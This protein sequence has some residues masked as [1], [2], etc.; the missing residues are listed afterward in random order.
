MRLVAFLLSG[1]TSHHHGMWRHP[2]T[3]NSFL[4]PEYY[5]HIARVLE[6]GYF[7]ALFFAD[8]LALSDFYKGSYETLMTRGGQMGLLDPMPMAA[9]MAR[10][11]KHIGLGVSVSSSFTHAFQTARTFA[12][13]DHLSGGRMAWN[14]VTSSS[15]PTFA[16]FGQAQIPRELRYDMADEVVEACTKLWES[17]EADAL[18][19]DKASGTFADASKIHRVDYEGQYVRTRGP[20]TVPRSPQGWPVLMQAGSSPRGREFAARW[21]EIIF[22]LQH[23]IPDMQD[24]RQDIHARMDKRGRR[25]EECQILVSVDPILGESRGMAEEKAAYL[26]ELIDPELGLALISAHIGTDLSRYPLHQPL[27]EVEIAEGSRGSLDVILQGTRS[28]GLSL[29][30]AAKRFAVSELCPQVIGTAADIADQL[31]AMFDSGGC[32]GFVLTPTTFPGC[33]EQFSRAVVPELQRRGLVRT[34]YDGKTLRENLQA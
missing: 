32:D 27:E 25:P 19:L 11:T 7:D 3:D 30:E 2:E 8:V 34:R 31:Q 9:Q 29:G 6:A 28:S 4:T 18:V 22:T 13:M 17:W 24:F 20:L 14:I 26:Q 15:S 33:F 16:N 21:A 5:E 1:P 10:V 23:S 12:T